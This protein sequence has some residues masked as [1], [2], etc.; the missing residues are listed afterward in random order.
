MCEFR[1]LAKKLSGDFMTVG[2]STASIKFDGVL[3]V[4][5]L[6]WLGSPQA[7][8]SKFSEPIVGRPASVTANC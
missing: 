7:N 2:P 3:A 5:L 4:S 8:F 6:A 1:S